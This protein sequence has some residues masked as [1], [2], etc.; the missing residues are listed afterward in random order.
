MPARP[1]DPPGAPDP[2]ETLDALDALD[3]PPAGGFGARLPPA[4][5]GF[6][7]APPPPAPRSGIARSLVTA[8]VTL[9]VS[10]LMVGG[11]GVL[12]VVGLRKYLGGAKSSEVRNS[13]GQIAKDATAAY[14]RREPAGPGS[15]LGRVC[16]SA[17]RPVPEDPSSV[18]GKAYTS[19]R[20]EWEIDKPADA[21]FACL[22]FELTQP[23]FYQYRYEATPTSFVAVGRGDLD[24]DGRL[25]TFALRGAVEEGRV[26]LAPSIQETDPDE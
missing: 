22:G 15:S 12:G 3:V 9:A 17:S 24:G 16:P 19:T 2:R 5:R 11:L 10:I 20:F 13:L 7:F 8:L 4:A 6:G 18:R 26:V 14:E 1:P 25:S 23:Q 21:G